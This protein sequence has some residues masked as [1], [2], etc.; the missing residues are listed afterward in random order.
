MQFARL[1]LCHIAETRDWQLL[2]EVEPGSTWV[3]AVPRGP[4]LKVNG[5]ATFACSDGFGVSA[6]LVLC[7]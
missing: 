6:L 4:P 5:N 1:C 3:V 2:C 7:D